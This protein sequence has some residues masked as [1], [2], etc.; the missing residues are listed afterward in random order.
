M[1]NRRK[2]L[3]G[4][5]ATAAVTPCMTSFAS[6]LT[7]LGSSVAKADTTGDYKALVCVFLY[8][9]MDNH[10]VVIPYDKQNYNHWASIRRALMSPT[11]RRSRNDLLPLSNVQGSQQFALPPELSEL[12]ALYERGNAAIMANVGPLIQPTDATRF[13]KVPDL[14]PARLF[15]HNDQQSTWMSG[16]PE[17]ARYGWG[18]RM[19]DALIQLG[20][21]PNTPFNNISTDAGELMLTGIKSYPYRVEGG[22]AIQPEL[23]EETDDELRAHLIQHFRSANFTS[24]NPI[25][26]DLASKMTQSFDANQSYNRAT[27]DIQLSTHFPDTELGTQLQS[28][29]NTM[30]AR[31]QLGVSRQLFS[32]G[33]GG[34]DTHSNQATTLPQLQQQLSKAITAFYAAL[35]ELGLE[36]QVTLFTASDFGR[37]LAVNDDGTDH[38]WGG[39]HFVVGGAVQGRQILGTVPP[40][41][42]GHGQDAGNGRLIPTTSVDQYAAAFG[43]WLGVS[44]NILS[45]IFP[46]LK[47]FPTLNGMFTS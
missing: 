46:N 17:G 25:Q 36:K 21:T 41:T 19:S 8:G 10:D 39:H 4:S 2:F 1:M 5:L 11:T 15:S 32:V 20:S 3:K 40:P 24:A 13:A 26:Q 43:S 37:T 9:G 45:E 6:L 30:A 29:A 7:S 23:I 44:E 16:S 38:G 47:N 33:L 35:Q 42:L 31:H 34:F 18:G 28:V 27:R 22:Q 14:Q 12:H